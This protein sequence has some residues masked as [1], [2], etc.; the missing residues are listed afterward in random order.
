MSA[1]K[2][3]RTTGP[4]PSVTQHQPPANQAVPLTA[5]WHTVPPELLH[6]SSTF[7]L[8]SPSF[9][10]VQLLCRLSAV[11]VD[12]HGMVYRTDGGAGRADFWAGFTA[13]VAKRQNGREVSVADKAFPVA[14]LPH[15]LASLRAVRSLT[16]DFGQRRTL[17]G[18]AEGLNELQLYTR[19]TCLQI[20]LSG[21]YN[22][23]SI[24]VV[25][26][27]QTALD[28]ALDF[29]ASRS[30]P[31]TSLALHCCNWRTDPANVVRPTTAVLQRLCPSVQHLSLTALELLLM[32][33]GTY[34]PAD[35]SSGS[36]WMAHSVQSLVF[37]PLSYFG[38]LDNQQAVATVAAA[39]PS[40]THLHIDGEQQVA[41]VDVLLRRVCNR[42]AFLRCNTIQLLQ[43]PSVAASMTALKSLCIIDFSHRRYHEMTDQQVRGAFASLTSCTA[44]RELTFI[45]AKRLPFPINAM[46]VTALPQLT[47]PE[48]FLRVCN[49][50]VKAK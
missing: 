16:L 32:A 47:Y 50:L 48:R 10:F 30:T 21:A 45:A 37:P 3:A 2:R 5:R 28:A 1:R 44:L 33:W 39:L 7:V 41:H 13:S 43:L 35:L 36:V 25:G 46:F 29:L 42:L 40:A 19:L 4:T 26:K 15:A 11:C 9:P 6:Y 27:V 24:N 12:W 18:I 23:Q 17:Q 34:S 8:G 22:G 20:D 31:L 38:Y 14:V 49:R